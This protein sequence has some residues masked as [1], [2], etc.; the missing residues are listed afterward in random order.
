M[1]HGNSCYTVF[2]QLQ[3]FAHF[4]ARECACSPPAFEDTD[5]ADTSVK[6]DAGQGCPAGATGP[7]G[8]NSTT[9]TVSG[10]GS[11]LSKMECPKDEG[12]GRNMV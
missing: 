8:G 12:T 1:S 2:P 4:Q 10:I 11:W 6:S 5:G 7:G 9:M 3:T